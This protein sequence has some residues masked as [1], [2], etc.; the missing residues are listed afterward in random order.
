MPAVDVVATDHFAM[1]AEFHAQSSSTTRVE[2]SV[3]TKDNEG[4]VTC[5]TGGL[6]SINE[7]ETVYKYC[8]GETTDI[9]TDL[10][11]ALTAFGGV[12]DSKVV[13]ELTI[14]FEPGDYATVTVRGMQA[15]ENAITAINVADVSG[16]VPAS[17]GFGVPALAG[18]TLGSNA[19]EAGLEI[20]FG[21]N[22]ISSVGGDGNH[23]VTQAAGEFRADGT[24]SYVG[25]PTT[26][27]PVTS[28]VTDGFETTDGNSEFDAASWT[29]HRF[30]DMT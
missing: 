24:A 30:F 11:T 10:G 29:G 28:W 6:N 21:Y 9:K 22:L 26:L 12:R 7:Y 23:F 20:K 5:E 19:D 8:P 4:N 2:T 3:Q 13:T 25:V 16:A 1:E 14:S 17:A 15:V 18:V 27:Q